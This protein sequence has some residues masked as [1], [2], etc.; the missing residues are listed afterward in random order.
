M[1]AGQSCGLKAILNKTR[2]KQLSYIT[3]LIIKIA[4]QHCG[5]AY[6]FRP[7]LSFG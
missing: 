3:Q 5:E 1:I 6:F 4:S 7:F 2:K